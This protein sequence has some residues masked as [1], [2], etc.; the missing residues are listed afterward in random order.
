MRE[1]MWN[2]VYFGPFLRA[3]RI[4]GWSIASTRCN[5]LPD[6]SRP[7]SVVA[8]GGIYH[9]HD[10]RKNWDTMTAVFDY[11]PIDEGA[12][13]AAKGFQVLY[14]ARMTNSAGGVREHYFLK[15]RHAGSGKRHGDC[16]RRADR[17]VREGNG[18]EAE[19]AR[20]DFVSATGN[21]SDDRTR[22]IRRAPVDGY[23]ALERIGSGT[24]VSPALTDAAAAPD[25]DTAANMRDWMECVQARKRPKR[26][27]RS[28]LQPLRGAVHDDRG[29]ADRTAR[30]VRRC[31]AG[32][33]RGR[34]DRPYP[35]A[36]WRL[37]T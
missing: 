32:S 12:T 8:N 27:H 24:T 5:G 2:F 28:G 30:F 17:G 18:H 23:G 25:E 19:S 6:C 29:N 35:S 34:P 20:A 31:Q 3:F 22:G 11:G 15:R 1:N 7:R 37:A 4:N 33:R 21:R 36:T 16:D 10:G 26:R 14:T 13:G 9:W